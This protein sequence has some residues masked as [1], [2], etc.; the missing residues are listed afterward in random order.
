[1][2]IRRLIKAMLPMGLAIALM[3]IAGAIL[4]VWLY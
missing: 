4:A 2:S 1:M 3:I